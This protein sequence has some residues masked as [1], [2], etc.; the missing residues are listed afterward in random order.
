MAFWHFLRVK[1]VWRGYRVHPCWWWCS[2]SLRFLL[3]LRETSAAF[4]HKPTCCSIGFWIAFTWTAATVHMYI[5]LYMSW[6]V[7]WYLLVNEAAGNEQQLALCDHPLYRN[8]YTVCYENRCVNF[9]PFL[10]VV[11]P[12]P[13]LSLGYLCSICH[14][15]ENKN[16]NW[17]F[18]DTNEDLLCGVKSTLCSCDILYVLLKPNQKCIDYSS[19]SQVW[20]IF[21]E[22]YGE[23]EKIERWIGSFKT[24]QNHFCRTRFKIGF[25]SALSPAIWFPLTGCSH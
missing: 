21:H 3:R 22:T 13:G 17:W 4:G 25:S 6:N 11:F 24:T 9:I 23:E 18:T 16:V 2:T 19:K 10:I 7:V 12:V 20:P 15:I 14:K 5:Y 8:S 1:R